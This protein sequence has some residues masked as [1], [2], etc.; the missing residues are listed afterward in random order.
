MGTTGRSLLLTGAVAAFLAVALGAFGAHALK[1]TLHMDAR[2][3]A[4]WETGVQYHLAHALA[5]LFVGLACDRFTAAPSLVRL[6]GRLLTAGIVIFGGSL[7]ALALTSLSASGP[8]RILGAITPLGGVCFLTGW[9]L[10]AVAVARE[11]TPPSDR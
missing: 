7:Y 6:A 2:W 4:V 8:V 9:A 1:E 11:K 5:L 3:L 10:L